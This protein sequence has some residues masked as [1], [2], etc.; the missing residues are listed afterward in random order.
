[1]ASEGCKIQEI[2]L[3]FFRHRGVFMVFSKSYNLGL[4]LSKLHVSQ[5]YMTTGTEQS[6]KTLKS[7][8]LQ[9]GSQQQ[10][11]SHWAGDRSQT[12]KA[13]TTERREWMQSV[14]ISR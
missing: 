7:T 12:H 13:A 6:E 3:E 10:L 2:R 14:T 8:E 4:I 9:S 5:T 11:T 1:M